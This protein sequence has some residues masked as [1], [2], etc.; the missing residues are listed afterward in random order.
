M[1]LTYKDFKVGQELICVKQDTEN[2]NGGE[3]DNERLILG[4]TYKITDV[5]YHFPNSVCVQLIGPI[6]FHDEFVPIECFSDVAYIRDK[7]LKDLGI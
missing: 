3:K 2:Y 1:Q 5:E 4:E 7:K 6:Y